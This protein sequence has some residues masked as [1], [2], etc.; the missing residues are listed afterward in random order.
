MTP[1]TTRV[2]HQKVYERPKWRFSLFV[3]F[4]F[5]FCG[6]R[7][8]PDYDGHVFFCLIFFGTWKELFLGDLIFRW[9]FDT[10]GFLFSP[11]LFPP[12]TF[13]FRARGGCFC[14]T[15][16][17]MIG[18]DQT[19]LGRRF[20]FEKYSTRPDLVTG[21]VGASRLASARAAVA[22]WGGHL[23]C[24]CARTPVHIRS[25][26]PST[27]LALLAY[28]KGRPAGQDAERAADAPTQD[29]ASVRRPYKRRRR[30]GVQ[31]LGTAS[32]SVA[33]N[34]SRQQQA[35]E[36]LRRARL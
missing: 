35:S 27:S 26:A 15:L 22:R 3:V 1:A 31:F 6:S 19:H 18:P 2:K 20:V 23:M 7:C 13:C 21:S 25:H 12:R 11:V 17:L 14:T 8:S 30:G 28:C 36:R 29:I 24:T 16:R 9:R 34:K 32:G 5:S 10:P 4:I 33:A